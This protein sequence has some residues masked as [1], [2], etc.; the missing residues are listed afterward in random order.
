MTAA[1]PT[2]ATP[3]DPTLPLTLPCP[4]LPNAQVIINIKVALFRMDLDSENTLR[5][6]LAAVN[7]YASEDPVTAKSDFAQH[8]KAEVN[9]IFVILRNK[10]NMVAYHDDIDTMTDMHHHIAQ[11][12]MNTPDLRLATLMTIQRFHARVCL[13]R[14]QRGGR[15][16][17][18]EVEEK[19]A[20]DH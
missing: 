19:S 17:G 2:R 13:Q 8:V 18:G 3:P 5:R 10:V 7:Q 9:N 15:E 6:S 16:S 12:A 20:K 1:H 4:R 11:S 14:S